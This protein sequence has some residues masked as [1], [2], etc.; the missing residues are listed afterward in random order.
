[1]WLRWPIS[2]VTERL[3][4]NSEDAKDVGCK[5]DEHV[6]ERE[7]GDGD[8]DMTDPIKCLIGEDHLLNG[9]AHLVCA[10]S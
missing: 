5:D 7:E 3:T 6:D 4:N 10:Q 9:P 8:E 2:V 1:M